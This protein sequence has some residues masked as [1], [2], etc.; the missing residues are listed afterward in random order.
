MFFGLR[1]LWFRIF[2]V[3]GF[4]AFKVFIFECLGFR[5]FS[6]SSFFC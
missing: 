4:V 1:F 2:K 3:L 5:D 6:V